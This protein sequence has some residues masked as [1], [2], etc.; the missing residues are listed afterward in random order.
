ME[1]V[2]PENMDTVPGP[3]NE[4]Y[5][6]DCRV[7]NNLI[8][9]IGRIEKQVA[10]VQISM[11]MNIHV[12]NNSIYD[13]PRAGI[14]VSEGTWGGHII[15]YNDVF[16]TVLE[17]H[18]HGAFNSW[19]RDR[20]WV[21][22]N[23]DVME[24]CVRE[25]PQ[26]PYWDAMN[27]TIIRNNRFR[28]DHGWDIDLDDGSSNY[29]I[30]NNLCLSGGIKLREGFYRIVQN[31]IMVNNGFHPHVWFANSEDIF[32]NNIMMTRYRDIRLRGWGKEVDYNLFS[33]SAALALA[34]KNHTDANSLYGDP[35]FMNPAEGNFKVKE[36]S[37]AIE[38][39]F[40]N[41]SM[42]SF[43]VLKPQLKA[44][45]GQPE[46]PG[47]VFSSTT[48]SERKRAKWL[49][50][51]IK[52]IESKEEQSSFGLNTRDG[53]IIARAPEGSKLSQ[54]GI[55]AGDVI[56][57]INDQKITGMDDLMDAYGKMSAYREIVFDL[58]RNQQAV[59]ISLK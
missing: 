34:R 42:D 12:K 33:D 29:Y 6:A 59:K 4:Q 55:L 15:E 56:V 30:Y 20:F 43:G 27:T 10:G 40:V 21:P 46:I 19:G 52:D 35:L 53:V 32:R 18:D 44:I 38:I 9:R 31:N 8:Y 13:V 14:N 28:C 57:A 51:V 47:L 41:F 5:P 39:G 23:M 36:S 1:Y 48:I 11:A 45:A 37:P 7:E 2:D 17:T 26:M 22:R 24:T 49:G 50:G 16:N 3:G 54:S 58:V 25:N